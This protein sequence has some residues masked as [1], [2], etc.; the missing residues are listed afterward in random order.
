MTSV[1]PSTKSFTRRGVSPAHVEKQIRFLTWDEVERI[2]SYLDPHVHRIVPLAAL[3]GMRRGELY[4]LTDTQIDLS[5]G[6]ITLRVT[7]TRRPRKVWL[8]NEAKKLLREQLLVRTPNKTGLVF[9]TR[10]GAPLGSRFESAFRLAVELA[11]LKGA[12]FH[13]LRHTAAS[14]LIAAKANPLEIAEQLGHLS[15]GKPDPT[16]I[17]KRYGWLYEGATKSAVLRLD[18]LIASAP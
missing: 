14:L 12:T 17:W 9:T 2:A 6:T 8:S 7:K 3:T 1:S 4:A 13:A 18:E 15:G 11:E 16:M 5:A 10:S